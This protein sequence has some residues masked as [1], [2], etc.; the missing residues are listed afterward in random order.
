M[1]EA[2]GFENFVAL[3]AGGFGSVFRATRTS[4]RG[5]V[6]IKVLDQ[7]LDVEAETVLRRVRREIEA[8]V[9]L[10][11]H[12]NVVQVEEMVTTTRGPAIVMEFMEGGAVLS[13]ATDS[14]LPAQTVANIGSSVAAALAAAHSAGI[15]HRDVK[16]KNVLTN[17][18]GQ[19][20]LC[21]FGISALPKTH[22]SQTRT[23][24][25]SLH[26]ASPEELDGAED[27]G[28]P[29]DVYSLGA[30]M[31]HLLHGRPPSFRSAL[32]GGD[33]GKSPEGAS[34]GLRAKLLDLCR[35]CLLPE[36]AGRPTADAVS[37][38]IASFSI[39]PRIEA[40][41]EPQVVVDDRTVIRQRRPRA[42]PVDDRTV[43]R[44]RPDAEKI[45]DL[46]NRYE[47]NWWK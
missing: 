39:Q 5:P 43:N 41:I 6:A 11:G 15:I 36:P 12:P 22:D 29:T 28:S 34:E 37:A 13:A 14:R 20:K 3:D 32:G 42:E 35:Q 21:D 8:L 25:L 40:A 46:P 4:T 23:A 44:S 10:K 31:F 30:T 19:I 27:V 45:H 7:I 9:A 26:Y 24:S 33:D 17:S 18:F 38:K 1:I 16:P 2:S 47:Q